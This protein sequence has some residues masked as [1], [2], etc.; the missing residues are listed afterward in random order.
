M[1]WITVS[2]LII[3]LGGILKVI[4]INSGDFSTSKNLRRTHLQGNLNLTIV[5]PVRNE[6]NNILRLLDSICRQKGQYEILVINDHSDDLTVLKIEQFIE[7]K[8]KNNIKIF[9][10]IEETNSPKK[11]AITLAIQKAKGDIIVT[12]DGDCIVPKNWIR[13]IEEAFQ[14]DKTKMLLG[15]VRYS[16]TKNLFETIQAYEL[17]ALLSLSL[18]MA[19]DKKPFT[20]NGANLA[21]RKETFLEVDGFDGIDQIASGDDEL[22]MKKIFS[23]DPDSITVQRD[24]FVDTF[25]NTTLIQFFHQRIRWASKWKYG[26][27]K[28]KMPGAFLML[29]YISLL[30]IPLSPTDN[31]INKVGVYFAFI[32]LFLKFIL[33]NI[34]IT[35]TYIQDNKKNDFS[36]LISFVLFIIYPFYVIIFGLTATFLKFSWKGRRLR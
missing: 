15:G 16:P 18:T 4:K 17:S 2:L 26:T 7:Q 5:V 35:M 33:D 24:A 22:L 12:T 6:E 28:E 29:L 36:Y 34:L 19:E 14:D 9:H 25:P 21:Y 13:V 27:W 30:L 23:K 8:K 32:L 3:Y 11:S 20:C 31:I 1:I 10:L